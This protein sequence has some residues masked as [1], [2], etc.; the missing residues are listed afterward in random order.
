MVD[1]DRMVH[2]GRVRVLFNGSPA[3]AIDDYADI[4]PEQV[5]DFG[6]RLGAD[7]LGID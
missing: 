1:Q 7:H 4:A 5:T 6:M 3:P 2:A